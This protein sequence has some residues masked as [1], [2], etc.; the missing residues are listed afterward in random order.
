MIWHPKPGQWVKINYKDK[1]LPYQASEGKVC[2]VGRT[3]KNALIKFGDNYV[4][5]PRGNLNDVRSRT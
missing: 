1:T 4:V 5:I 3:I 2:A